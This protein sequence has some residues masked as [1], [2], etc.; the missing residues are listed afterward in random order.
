MNYVGAHIFLSGVSIHSDNSLE[1][2][3]LIWFLFWSLCCATLLG[4]VLMLVSLAV[5]DGNRLH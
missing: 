1:R 2:Q 3:K 5:S 4:H